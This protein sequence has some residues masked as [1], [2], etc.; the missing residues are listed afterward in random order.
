MKA[1]DFEYSYKGI[2]DSPKKKNPVKD[3][4][5]E[6][7]QEVQDEV[8]EDPDES[9]DSVPQMS[10]S[11][12]DD[13]MNSEDADSED[14]PH[15]LWCICQ[16]PHN[17]R[18]MICCDNCLDWFHGKCVGITKKMGK[19]MEE[20]GNEWTCPKCKNQVEKEVTEKQNAELKDKLKERETTVT[21]K[22]SV[23]PKP[24]ESPAEPQKKVCFSLLFFLSKYKQKLE[25][26]NC[27]YESCKN[28]AKRT[29]V[30][31]DFFFVVLRR[32]D[33]LFLTFLFYLFRRSSRRKRVLCAVKILSKNP[34]TAQM[35]ASSSMPKKP[36]SYCEKT[37]P[38]P[39]V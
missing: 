12:E 2:N 32:F 13:D 31:L 4:K 19:E 9:K 8:M 23:T 1:G 17:N 10:E 29:R 21:K 38:S 16:Q 37:S 5:P 35:T 39:Q 25:F 15:K 36:L 14:D 34:F 3:F 20:A 22:K 11:D 28:S 18:F 27:F 7:D 24:K 6:E 33:E 30:M 26:L